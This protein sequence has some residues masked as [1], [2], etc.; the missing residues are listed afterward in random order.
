MLVNVNIYV[1][2]HVPLLEYQQ[3][4]ECSRWRLQHADMVVEMIQMAGSI[5]ILGV[6][7]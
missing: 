5:I 6:V 2:Y 1:S 4:D 3:M 7:G